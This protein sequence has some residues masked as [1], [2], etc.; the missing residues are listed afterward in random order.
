MWDASTEEH[1]SMYYVRKKTKHSGWVQSLKDILSYIKPGSFK[2][3]FCRKPMVKKHIIKIAVLFLNEIKSS[4]NNA[5][6]D[7]FQHHVVL[8]P[9]SY[10]NQKIILTFYLFHFFDFNCFFTHSWC[11]LQCYCVWAIG[12]SF[13]ARAGTSST[14]SLG[15]VTMDRW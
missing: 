7:H 11:A 14:S 1:L 13:S 2:F 8:L 12:C 5:D 15:A 9:H 4:I 10:L 6:N 3:C